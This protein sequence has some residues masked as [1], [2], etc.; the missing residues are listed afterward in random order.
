MIYLGDNWPDRYRNAVFTCNLH[1]R[2]V[3]HDRLERQGSGYVAHH[4]RDF[5]MA[6]DSWFR[7]LEMKYGPDGGVYVT[8]WYDTGECHE[9]DA[10]NAHRENGRIYKVAYGK[11]SPVQVD[12]S[13]LDDVA[14][15]RLQLHRNE[16]YV[17]TSRRLLQERAAADA[18]WRRRIASCREI[19]ESNADVTRQLRAMWALHATGG[20]DAAA[21]RA[22]LDHPSEHIRAWGVRLL[23]DATTP[24]PAALSQ[25]AELAK[26]D[27]SPKVRLSLASIVRRLPLADR[28]SIVESLATHKEDATDRMLPLM[29]WYAAEPLVT[30]DRSRAMSVAAVCQIPTVRRFMARRTVEA[31]PTAGLAAVLGLLKS[32]DSAACFDLLIGTHDGL[33]RKKSP[34]PRAGRTSLPI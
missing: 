15:A 5:L 20:L 24:A 34:V 22:L 17:R 25:F 16:W 13:R 23:C 1:G 26:M 12:L 32:A 10:D 28:W 18:T 14:L 9:A 8:D 6:N 2:R 4:E 11:L 31:D 29:I 7:G 19:L 30:A 27:P 21:A 3:N 33:R